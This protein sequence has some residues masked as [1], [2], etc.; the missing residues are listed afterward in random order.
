[1]RKLLLFA[2]LAIA[3]A[4]STI[5]KREVRTT[6]NDNWLYL[7]K[8]T[9]Q[10]PAAPDSAYNQISLP[11]TWNDKDTLITK[12]YRR[13]A[14]WYRK[15]LTFSDADLKQR[16]YLRFGAAGQRAVVYVNGTQSMEHIGGYSAFTLEL[17]DLVKVGKNKIDVMVTNKY[18]KMIAPLS[19][20][21]NMYGGLYRS[22]QLIKAPKESISRK[23]LGGP[24]FRIWSE[25]VSA[26]KGDLN[27]SA[28][29]DNGT[30]IDGF[31]KLQAILKDPEG[32]IVSKGET[33]A[34]VKA[35]KVGHFTFA[36]PE[37]V[38]PEL[39]SPENPILYTL[40]VALVKNGNVIDMVATNH[41]FRW[42]KFTAD[43]G[44]FL[45]G[46]PYKLIGVN[47]HQDFYMEG[48]AVSPKRHEDD[49]KLMKELGINWLRLAHY[50]Q[51]DYVLELCD[52]MGM[53]VWEEIPYVN[54]TT[55]E[56]EF[57]NNMRSMMKDMIEQHFNHPSIVLWGMGN[58]VWMKPDA[59]GKARCW[60][61]INRLNNLIHEQDPVRKSVF[62]I[63]DA[64]YAWKLKVMEI[65]DVIGYNLYRGWYGAG[66]ETFTARC[67]DLHSKN[68]DKPFIVS[69]F[70]AGC[71]RNIHS[72][73][74]RR[75]DFSEEYQINFLESHLDQ[76]EKIDWLS[77]FNWWN[78]ADFGAAH[79]GDSIPH[80]NQK[81]FIT[82]D[83]QK[84]IA[85]TL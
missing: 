9:V 78:F 29:V 21:F 59:D 71:D 1:M 65:P 84:K 69:E 66:Y 30:E 63:G 32:K 42:F 67:E 80:V 56:P 60:S 22:V 37:I 20:D 53:L 46:K 23:T 8:D 83:R 43:K 61:I 49:M 18:D 68:P 79:R 19:G 39:W 72:E 28:Y 3:S 47:R 45:N 44:F 82:F 35:R 58:E 51:D 26:E 74:P 14:S 36:L 6:L 75:Y 76:I 50:Q 73:S 33:S 85:S 12:K 70:G 25:K 16:L 64:N 34:K 2:A 48:N 27:V 40:S 31:Y 5:S 38:N 55:F 57:E 54:G 7:E 4:C 24:G 10:L 81:G 11:H 52:K 41:G 77:G 62:V 13:S 17:T 15:Y